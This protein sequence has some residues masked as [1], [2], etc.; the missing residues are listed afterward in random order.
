MRSIIR[1]VTLTM[2]TILTSCSATHRINQETVT[3]LTHDTYPAKNPQSVSL[4]ND[5][6]KPNAAYRV[7]GIATVSK[8]N[9]LG[10]KRPNDTLDFMIKNLAASI[11]GDG[12]IEISQTDQDIKAKV[13]AYQK[14]LI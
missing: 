7:I 13:I 9:L 1:L 12:V 8:Y 4:Y 14:L 10:K 6:N 3:P 5:D 11:G 2:I